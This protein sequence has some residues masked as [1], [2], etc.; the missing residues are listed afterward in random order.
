MTAGRRYAPVISM[1]LLAAWIAVA[2]FIAAVVAPAAFAVL[3]TRTLAGAMVGR[4]LPVLFW[5]GI[6]VG[7]AVIVLRATVARVAAIGGLVLL[8][9]NA[10]ALTIEHR[11]HALLVSLGGPIDS[12]AISDPRRIAFGRM[13]GL[14]VLCMAVGLVGASVALIVLLRQALGEH[15]AATPPLS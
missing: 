11:L 14:S 4:V 1:N 15:P 8:A 7:A 2:V 9:G 13:H 3:P 5:S 10:V 6:V 12:I